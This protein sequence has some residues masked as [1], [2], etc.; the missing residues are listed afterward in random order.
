[1]GMWYRPCLQDAAAA[2]QCHAQLAAAY[3]A[4]GK[5]LEAEAAHRAAGA[6]DQA[7]AVWLRAGQWEA[8][9]RCAAACMQPGA[10]H[11]MLAEHAQRAEDGQAW[12][13]AEC[14]WL[15]AGEVDAAVLMRRRCGDYDGMLRLVSEHRPVRRLT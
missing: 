3:E 13:E 4:A 5:L 12:A 9:Q 1:M 15:A 11:D 2:K 6:P 8:A 10:A 7:V 14:A